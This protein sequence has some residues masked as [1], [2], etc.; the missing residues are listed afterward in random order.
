MER[1]TPQSQLTSRTTC[2]CD[3]CIWLRDLPQG[4]VEQWRAV[5]NLNLWTC[6]FTYMCT[7]AKPSVGLHAC[8]PSTCDAKVVSVGI[9]TLW[10][11]NR[12]RFYLLLYNQLLKKWWFM[13]IADTCF[14]PKPESWIWC[15]KFDSL[16]WPLFMSS[17]FWHESPGRNTLLRV[18]WTLRLGCRPDYCHLAVLGRNPLPGVLG[19]GQ[20]KSALR[21]YLLATCQSGNLSSSVGHL[22]FRAGN[23]ELLCC[24]NSSVL[25]IFFMKSLVL[26]NRFPNYVLPTLS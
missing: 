1:W 26:L 6:T 2:V 22:L 20:R 9:S 19:C 11:F 4:K 5:L 21:A 14:I 24:L 7:N 3:L 16:I 10:G 25:K 8:N 13:T 15:C 12:S 18:S 17:Q 23:E